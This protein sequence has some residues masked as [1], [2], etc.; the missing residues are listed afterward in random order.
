MSTGEFQTLGL[1]ITCSGHPSCWTTL[2]S[3]HCAITPRGRLLADVTNL[4]SSYAHTHSAFGGFDTAS[5][6]IT[7]TQGRGG[8]VV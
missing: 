5:F 1:S 2:A 6:S 7:A 8:D 4:V 3:H